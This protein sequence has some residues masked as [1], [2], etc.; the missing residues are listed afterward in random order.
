MTKIGK[1]LERTAMAL[2]S[3]ALL[4]FPLAWAAVLTDHAPESTVAWATIAAAALGFIDLCLFW[5]ADRVA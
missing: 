2:I 4:G 3:I 1:R 5:V